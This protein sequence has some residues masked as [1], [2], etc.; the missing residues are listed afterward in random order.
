MSFKIS[1]FVCLNNFNP[2]FPTPF[3]GP[4]GETARRQYILEMALFL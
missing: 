3:R 2:V 1:I 4:Q